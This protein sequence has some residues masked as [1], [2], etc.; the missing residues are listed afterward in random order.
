[1]EKEEAVKRVDAL[2]LCSKC[3]NVVDI[4]D[5]NRFKKLSDECWHTGCYPYDDTLPG[6]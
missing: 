4:D 2:E 1:M 5:E 6:V 3:G